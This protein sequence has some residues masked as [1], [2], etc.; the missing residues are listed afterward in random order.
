MNFTIGDEIDVD[1][2]D[3]YVKYDRDDWYLESAT[4]ED[5]DHKEEVAYLKVVSVAED[6]LDDEELFIGPIPFKVME[7]AYEDVKVKQDYY[8]QGFYGFSILVMIF[9]LCL[10]ISG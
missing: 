5:I 3:K 1:S 9:S 8:I 10:L 4:I 2:I 6:G 7:K